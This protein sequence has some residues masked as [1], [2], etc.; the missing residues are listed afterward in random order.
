M[1]EKSHGLPYTP[2]IETLSRIATFYWSAI[3]F[4]R[5]MLCDASP[6][7]SLHKEAV[8]KITRILYYRY[9][10][11]SEKRRQIRVVWPTFMVAIE[12]HDP[13]HRGW[14]IERLAEARGLS[15]EC[16]KLWGMANDIIRQQE[17]SKG[18]VVDLGMYMQP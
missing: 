11:D 9:H 6:Q 3:L 8:S 14:M 15:A 13:I 10:K 16:E 5:R 18:F 12:T 7:T 2:N 1:A 17:I 4:H